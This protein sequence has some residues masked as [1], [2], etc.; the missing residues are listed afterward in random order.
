MLTLN[1]TKLYPR[2]NEIA[3][4]G[5]SAGG[6]T[7]QRYALSTVLPPQLRE[8]LDLRFILANPSSYAYLSDTR[9]KY[10]CGIC[11]CNTQECDCSG[12]CELA[13]QEDAYLKIPFETPKNTFSRDDSEGFVCGHRY[14]DNWPYGMSD[15]LPYAALNSLNKSLALYPERD[16]VY[17]VGQNDT[18]N[19]NLPFCNDDCWQKDND[20]FRNSMDTRCPAMLQGPWRKLR[21]QLYQRFLKRFY[22]RK[23]HHFAIVDG[24]G[25]NASSIFNSQM[26]LKFVFHLNHTTM[27]EDPWEP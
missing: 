12:D 4:I 20:C 26:A 23:I 2:M 3:L 27:A 9:P 15:R 16:V 19:D 8:G 24:S 21:G 1:D 22:G 18:C 11:D 14:Y 10:K 7:V 17:L 13:R 6:Q 5:H 25:H